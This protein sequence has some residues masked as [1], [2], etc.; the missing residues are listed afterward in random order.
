[1]TYRLTLSFSP[2]SDAKIFHLD[3]EIYSSGE[4]SESI[5]AVA[6]IEKCKNVSSTFEDSI[7]PCSQNLRQVCDVLILNNDEDC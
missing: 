3:K 2:A 1:M 4:K 5:I 6:E 7:E